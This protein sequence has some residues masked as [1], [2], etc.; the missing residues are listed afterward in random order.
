MPYL[1]N[2]P[3]GACLLAALKGTARHGLSAYE[4][5]LADTFNS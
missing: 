1:L 3:S 5:I 2:L 4:K